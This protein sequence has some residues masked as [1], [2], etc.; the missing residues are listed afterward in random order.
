MA[1]TI[2]HKQQS[3]QN[4]LTLMKVKMLDSV[5]SPIQ[6]YVHPDYHTQPTSTYEMTLGF[7][8]FTVLMKVL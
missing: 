8:L 2:A 1:K 3:E 4:E 6:D 7:K 5:N